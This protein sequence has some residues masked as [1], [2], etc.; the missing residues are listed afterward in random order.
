MCT[1]CFD[2]SGLR[3]ITI[4]STITEIGQS[5]FARCS[6]LSTVTFASGSTLTTIGGWAFD[7]SNISSITIPASVTS[8]G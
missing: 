2:N 1:T 4:P 8:I 5:A 7:N 3:S 6:S